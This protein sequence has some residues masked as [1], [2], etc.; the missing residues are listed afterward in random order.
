MNFRGKQRGA[1]ETGSWT[2]TEETPASEMGRGRRERGGIKMAYF[3]WVP[4][5]E[6]YRNIP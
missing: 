2:Q 3:L 6:G 5:S 1:R 4:T